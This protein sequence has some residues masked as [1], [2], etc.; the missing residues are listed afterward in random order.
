MNLSNWIQHL[1]IVPRCRGNAPSKLGMDAMLDFR[2]EVTLD[3]EKLSAAE[4]K[5][6]LARWPKPKIQIPPSLPPRGAPSDSGEEKQLTVRVTDQARVKIGR[7]C[8]R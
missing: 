6:L 2:L 3:G 4:I 1:L 8:S 5:R 7:S